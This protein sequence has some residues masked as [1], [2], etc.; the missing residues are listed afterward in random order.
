LLI[1][2][3]FI[4]Q[5][6]FENFIIPND[7]TQ[8]SLPGRCTHSSNEYSIRSK[9]KPRRCTDSLFL[10]DKDHCRGEQPR[11]GVPST[12]VRFASFDAFVPAVGLYSSASGLTLM[13]DGFS[14]A[15]GI[16]PVSGAP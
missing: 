4:R 12:S 14:I 5:R 2:A 3:A 9:F 10:G 16:G 7:S 1:T 13:V 6:E 11:S 8:L 15:L